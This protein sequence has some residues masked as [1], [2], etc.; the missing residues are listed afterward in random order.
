MLN[1]LVTP[2]KLQ[3]FSINVSILLFSLYKRNLNYFFTPTF[4]RILIII[5]I[6][7]KRKMK[8]YIFGKSSNF[9][10]YYLT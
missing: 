4:Y 1:N 6:T 10:N 3:N 7:N 9:L 8:I 5:I 2:L